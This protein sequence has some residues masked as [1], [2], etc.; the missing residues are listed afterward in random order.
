VLWGAIQCKWFLY[1]VY[2]MGF[3]RLRWTLFPWEYNKIYS[4][5][6][7]RGRTD[8]R[9]VYQFTFLLGKQG[10]Q[11]ERRFPLGDSRLTKKVYC[12]YLSLLSLP[13]LWP[14]FLVGILVCRLF[15]LLQKYHYHPQKPNSPVYDSCNLFWG[16]NDPQ[17]VYLFLENSK[18]LCSSVTEI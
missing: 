4:S 13:C 2:R 8:L 1:S 12:G 7:P 5:N 16:I 10:C 6:N 15:S 14:A 11:K 17:L 18:S 9:M 3:G